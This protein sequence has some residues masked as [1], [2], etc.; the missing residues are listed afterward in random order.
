MGFYKHANINA[1]VRLLSN[2]FESSIVED[3]YLINID[4]FIEYLCN[5]VYAKFKKSGTIVKLLNNVISIEKNGVTHRFEILSE[6]EFNIPS[7][8]ISRENT[9][10]PDLFVSWDR[11]SLI[12]F[13]IH[14][15]NQLKPPYECLGIRELVE[16]LTSYIINQLEL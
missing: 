9:H 7:I 15:F 6:S 5:A 16:V 10:H 8:L 13:N 4:N 12:T 3:N 1:T 2:K 14:Y 11:N